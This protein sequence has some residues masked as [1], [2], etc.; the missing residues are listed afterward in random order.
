MKKFIAQEIAAIL[1]FQN[2]VHRIPFPASMNY[3]KSIKVEPKRKRL[4]P[5]NCL[6]PIVGI[7]FILVEK[8]LMLDRIFLASY[9]QMPAP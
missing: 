1:Q 2:P 3:T 4:E 7:A 8:C 6:C 5:L 9:A